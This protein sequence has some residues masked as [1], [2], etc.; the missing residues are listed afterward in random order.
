VLHRSPSTIEDIVAEKP[1]AKPAVA[2]VNIGGESFL[3]RLIPHMKK[4]VV[5]GVAVLAVIAVVFMMRWRAESKREADTQRL[6]MTMFVAGQPIRVEGATP[7]PAAPGYAT[8]AEHAGAVLDSLAKNPTKTNTDLLSASM[9][10]EAGKFDEALTAYQK[11]ATLSGLDGVMAREGVGIA[12]ET[13]AQA[14]TDATAKQKGFEDA[15]AAFRTVQ[16]DEK[17]P[18]RVY[19]VYHEA[20]MLALLGKNADAKAAFEKAKALAKNSGLEQLIADRL[21]ALEAVGQ[22]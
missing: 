1:V 15:L 18:R 22:M 10:F 5:V 16:P 17:G 4:I 19:G 20:R 8:G 14:Q 9:L 12:L 3:D 2:A 21:T 6:A 7:D 13:K 11:A